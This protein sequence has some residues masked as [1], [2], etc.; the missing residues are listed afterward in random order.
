MLRV[1]RILREGKPSAKR[2]ETDLNVEL[3]LMFAPF[4]AMISDK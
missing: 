1:S 3:H 4:V 2:R